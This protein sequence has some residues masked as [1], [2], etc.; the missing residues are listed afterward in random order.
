M[1]VRREAGL[2][3]LIAI[4][5]L[6]SLGAAA[7]QPGETA[8]A[9]DSIRQQ[10]LR[11]DLFYLASG[12]MQG[13][14]SGTHT[15]NLAAE[16][17]K[18]RF[19]RMG[20]KPANGTFYQRYHLMSATLGDENL[21]EVIESDNARLRKKPGQDYYP[22]SFSASGVVRGSLVWAGFGIAAPEHSYDDYRGDR[23]RGKIVLA[24][25]H[26]PGERDAASP[27]DGLVPSESAT[28][29]RKALAA[30]E[31]GAAAILFVQDVHNHPEASNF[32]AAALAYWPEKPR[33][34]PS[35]T[36]ASW[37]EK[38]RIPAA[39]ISPA[40]AAILIRGSNRTLEDLSKAAESATGATP[41]PLPG[42]EVALTATVNRHVSAERNV[43]GMLDGADARLKDEVV[44]VCAHFD[45]EGADGSQVWAGADDDGS[46]TVGLIEIAEA[47]SIA[48]RAGQ[49]PRRSLLFAAWNSEERGLLGAWA[50][51]EKPLRPLENT[52]AVLNMD[53]IGRN[54]EVPEG[55]GSRFLGI[56]VQSADSNRNTLNIL[57]FSRSADMKAEVE[58][59]NQGFGLELKMRLDNHVS[60]L[61]ARSDHWPFL[62]RGVPALFF[63]TGLHPDYHTPSDRPEKINYPK[64]EKIVRLVHQM[65]WNLAQQDSRPKLNK[66][67]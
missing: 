54:E 32:E 27:F 14:L 43:V 36:L 6:L 11:A 52:V 49:R 17:I 26:E 46:G 21:L 33:R 63:H 20:L 12:A 15:N 39:Q 3:T 22:L 38:V 7:L 35:F 16:F 62:Q 50:Y 10:D 2:R 61:L 4:I 28:S 48:A 66:P 41:I 64:L 24:L 34:V 29:L 59:A 55:G 19:E 5:L 40:L 1:P 18:S 45:H 9:G 51:T 13:R 56:E 8:P 37:A 47:F 23:V 30:Q 44:I 67:M 65:S 58:K 42:P 60:N 57:G 25:D 53:M 31:R